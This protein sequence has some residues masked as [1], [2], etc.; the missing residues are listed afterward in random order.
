MGHSRGKMVTSVRVSSGTML[1]GD[2]VMRICRRAVVKR[3]KGYRRAQSSGTKDPCNR[4]LAL[5]SFES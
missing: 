3:Q 4:M 5:L 2:K 1:V